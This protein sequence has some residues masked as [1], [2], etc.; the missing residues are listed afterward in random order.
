MV[1]HHPAPELLAAFSAGSLPLSQAL[2]VG[3]HAEYC[4]ECQTNVQRLNNLGGQ[5]FENLQPSPVSEDFRNNVFSLLDEEPAEEKPKPVIT[6]THSDSIP[7]G[8][9]QFIPDGYD[10]L[11]W[12]RITS[13]IEATKLCTDSNGA[14]IEML[15]IRPGGNIATHTHTGDEFTMVIEGGFSDETG[16]Y[17]AGD[18]VFRD[19]SHKHRPMATKD[20]RCICLTV[21]DAPIAFTGFFT[22]WLNPFLKKTYTR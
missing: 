3:V 17:L 21:T 9:R 4:S 18:F 10:A 13:S 7:R 19:G 2:C 15:R 14:K 5:F 8:L 20:A 16:I 11:Q 12:Q 1:E 6:K 22:R